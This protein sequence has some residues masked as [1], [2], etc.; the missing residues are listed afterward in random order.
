MKR[1][2]IIGSLLL[3][4]SF[5]HAQYAEDALRYSQLYYQGTARNMATGSALGAMGAD[6]STLSTNPAGL[7]MYRKGEFSISP[8]VFNRKITS[9]YN[10]TA[11]EDARTMFDL[12][13]V[14]MVTSKNIGRG[15]NGWKYFNLGFGMNRLNNYNSNILIQGMNDENSRVDVY[16]NEAV[17][18]V[19]KSNQTISDAFSQESPF[20]IYPAWQTYLLDT[21]TIDGQLFIDSPVFYPSNNNQTGI[22]QSNYIETRGSNNEWLVSVGGNFNDKLYIGATLGLPYIRYYS[23]S[24]YA[25]SDPENNYPDFN[26]WSITEYLNTTGWGVNF[27]VGVIAKPLEWMRIGVAYHTPTYYWAM[28]DNWY[29]VTTTDLFA[30]SL[31]EWYEG[32]Y[33][34]PNG[35]FEYKLTTPMRFIANAGFIIKENGFITGAYEYVNYSNAKF[36][37]DYYSLSDVNLGIS[38]SFTATNNFRVGAEWRYS[39]LYFRGGYAYYANPYANNLNTG[40]RQSYTGGIGLRYSELAIDFAYVYSKMNTDYYLYSTPE[41]TT[42]AVTNAISSQNFVL[43]ISYRY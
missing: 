31:G 13:N 22:L 34:S 30:Y 38:S 9:T 25:E 21:I 16:V 3:M 29:T 8:E 11:S 23:E 43:S 24:L 15:A 37:A 14:G 17:D 36:K 12:S 35:E 40:Q 5:L 1:I 41:V 42:N 39:N 19:N 32:L 10:G 26:N 4:A 28:R 18:I 6:F 27:K 2:L 7:G 20:Y 33:S